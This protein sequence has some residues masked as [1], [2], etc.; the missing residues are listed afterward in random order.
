MLR[1]VVYGINTGLISGKKLNV[2]HCNSD[3]R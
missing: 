1:L 2:T 3:W